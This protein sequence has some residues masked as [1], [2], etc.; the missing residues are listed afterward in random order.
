MYASF[1]MILLLFNA[2]KSLRLIGFGRFVLN[3][4]ALLNTVACI[5][6]YYLYKTYLELHI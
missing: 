1:V 3:P 5:T 4:F 2:A 6:L